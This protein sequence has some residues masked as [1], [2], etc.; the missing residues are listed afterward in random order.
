MSLDSSNLTIENRTDAE[1]A[2]EIVRDAL[3]ESMSEMPKEEHIRVEI[4]DKEDDF[5]RSKMNGVMGVPRGESKLELIIDSR[6]GDWEQYLPA[7][8]A[9]EYAH[10]YY[11]EKWGQRFIDYKWRHLLQEA[12]SQNFAEKVY[13][14]IKAP[15][16]E[17]IPQEKVSELWP[18]IRDEWLD[19]ESVGQGDPLFHGTGKFPDWL[20]YSLAYYLGKELM[21]SG[22]ELEEFPELGKEEVVKAGE[23]LF[24]S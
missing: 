10:T 15:M 9:H 8:V 16:R 4:E 12:H 17:H 1:T 6:N 21:E 2:G 11:S 3:N 23:K 13:P 14:N 5:I 18:E 19:R 20:G 22:Y 7:M 24:T